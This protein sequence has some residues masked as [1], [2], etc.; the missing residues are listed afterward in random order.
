[1]L[2]QRV[3]ILVKIADRVS[4]SVKE[5]VTLIHVLDERVVFRHGAVLD[6]VIGAEI[7]R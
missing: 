4:T 3:L 1:M 5:L 7:N 2:R 6:V